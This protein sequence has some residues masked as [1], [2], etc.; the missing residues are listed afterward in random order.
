MSRSMVRAYFIGH[1]FRNE[2]R[3]WY[4]VKARWVEN[5]FGNRFYFDVYGSKWLAFDEN[6]R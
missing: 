5:E 6:G 4:K 2:L 3:G 1:F